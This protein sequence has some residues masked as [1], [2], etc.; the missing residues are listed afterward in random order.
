MNVLSSSKRLPGA[1]VGVLLVAGALIGT[2][3]LA[4][5][6]LAQDEATQIAGTGAYMDYE[7]LRDKRVARFKPE[8]LVL[9]PNLFLIPDGVDALSL[10]ISVL[11]TNPVSS[12]NFHDLASEVRVRRMVWK[13]KLLCG[14]GASKVLAKGSRRIEY[15]SGVASRQIPSPDFSICNAATL[16]TED[17]REP[18]ESLL[19]QVRFKGSEFKE[20]DKARVIAY[21]GVPGY[22]I[23]SS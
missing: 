1:A 9:T 23:R 21:W 7:F 12:S 17:A 5:K 22:A 13:L 3:S 18:T 2:F 8:P 20:G 16:G 15:G 4:P 14:N 10:T 6:V 19:V 11:L